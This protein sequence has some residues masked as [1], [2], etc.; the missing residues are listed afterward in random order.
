MAIILSDNI[1]TN[2]SKPTDSRYYDNLLPYASVSAANIAI[3]GGVRYTGLTV[4]ILGVEYWYG[5]GI[6]DS[7]LVVKAANVSVP[8]TGATNLGSGNGKIRL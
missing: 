4:N 5:A 7:C 6:A 8:V 3:V 2:A 1:Q